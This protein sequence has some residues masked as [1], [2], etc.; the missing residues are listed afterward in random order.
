MSILDA[1]S[2]VCSGQDEQLLSLLK[3]EEKLTDSTSKRRHP[4]G[5]AEPRGPA[6]NAP[7]DGIISR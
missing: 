3:P 6:P 2:I 7:P 1:G 5:S 4:A